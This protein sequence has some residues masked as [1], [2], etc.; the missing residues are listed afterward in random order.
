MTQLILAG[1]IAGYLVYLARKTR[2]SKQYALPTL[3][4]AAA[5]TSL[6]YALFLLFLNASLKPDWSFY[7]MPL[8][9][10]VVALF[11]LLLL[12]FAY[13]FPDL[14]SQ[15][16]REARAALGLCAFYMMAEA[17]F[18]ALRYRALAQGAVLYRP[19][20]MDYFML[21]GFGWV[22]VIFLRQSVRLSGGGSETPLQKLW[23]PRNPAA[24]ATRAL[25]LV[26]LLMVALSLIEVLHSLDLLD[27]IVR[28][29][30]LAF[31]ILVT[32]GAFTLIYLNFL[33]ETT[34]FMVK[35]V[36]VSLAVVLGILGAVGW[37]IAPPY[38]AA[39]DDEN[40]IRGRLTLRFTP[41]R[42][43]A[44]DVEAAP[45][46]FDT[47]FGRP[48]KDEEAVQLPFPFPY[49]SQ[50]W[51]TAYVL[52]NGVLSFGQSFSR[53]NARYRYGASPAIAP[54]YMNLS[55]SAE[56]DAAARKGVFVQTS[57]EKMIVTWSQM[58]EANEPSRAYTFQLAL[59]PD[60]SFEINYADFPE[61]QVFRSDDLVDLSRFTALISG[62]T[63]PRIQR[64]HF[65]TDLPFKGHDYDVLV[66]D[67]YLAFREYLHRL[68]LPLAYVVGLSSLF[69]VLFFP[70]FFRFNLLSPL[71][72]LLQGIRE[73]N[74][75]NL[76]VSMP[77]QFHDEIGFLTESF[78]DMASELNKRSV[79]LQKRAEGLES[80]A[81]ISSAIRQATTKAEIITLLTGEIAR[82]EEVSRGAIFLLENGQ[83]V[84]AGHHKTTG[85]VAGHRL[86]LD[87]MSCWRAL[88]RG[89][90]IRSDR[91]DS[92]A[93]ND[94]DL[95]AMHTYP[96]ETQALLPLQDADQTLGL[97]Y[98]SFRCS[99][100]EL[101]ELLPT[102]V[103]MAEMGGNALQRVRTVEM[104]EQ[105]VQART[106]E[107]TTLVEVAAATTRFTALQPM[108]EEML[109]KTL[110]AIKGELA[111]IHLF[112]EPVVIIRQ[113][114]SENKSSLFYDF[115]SDVTKLSDLEQEALTRQAPAIMNEREL[116][117]MWPNAQ[118]LQKRVWI[119]FPI[120]VAGQTCGVFSLFADAKRVFSVED[121]VLLT[122]IVD[123]IGLAVESVGL[124]R[125]VRE[126]AAQE[127]RSRLGRDL[128][129]SV[130]Q[131]LH[132]LVLLA[133][134][135]RYLVQADRTE[136]LSDSLERLSESA[137]QALKEMRLLLFRLRKDNQ[138]EINI[139][140]DLRTRLESVERRAG[141]R[142]R[143]VVEGSIDW[144]AEWQTEL[145]GIAIEALN[146]ALQHAHATQ[147][148][149]LVKG[150]RDWALL[151][152][153]DNGQGFD[154]EKPVAGGMGL[155]IM[156]ERAQRLGAEFLIDAAPGR[157]VCVRVLL[158][159]NAEKG[160]PNA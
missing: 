106:R 93:C 23:R 48:I 83:L 64:I 128:H 73:I 61:K 109:D 84:Q 76:D 112:T 35:L 44:Y 97:L 155:Q 152:I 135:A 86:R 10:V 113:A 80:L 65:K 30:A 119:G 38:I 96:S 46:R 140:E 85:I 50:T 118:I 79:A 131:S 78:N 49:F 141:I 45:F 43:G 7:V 52:K 149:I 15:W 72:R 25:A 123:H 147:V 17:A 47:D 57:P 88:R 114:Q 126:A 2:L 67:Y 160:A 120:Q 70:V 122:S 31:G 9:S 74:S 77:V 68:F 22:G 4:I 157:G 18:A 159:R 39:Y 55:A 104:L 146:N 75:G 62:T 40:M 130:T 21:A 107:L 142:V 145:R 111:I 66:E 37:I 1:A 26:G 69:I 24:R 27:S 34:S 28:D 150:E 36:G 29:L 154:P 91:I 13:R 101:D 5:L 105:L 8:E 153:T 32:L 81:H 51:Q 121:I 158:N 6:T 82:A 129:D 16:R 94:C 133:D 124:R 20:S 33:P 58:T 100:A 148:S 117:A 144:P 56:A 90:I 60:G 89:M 132:S 151:E 116:M 54:F 59:F 137:R 42:L 19:A 98:L 115:V 92:L 156:A 41:N 71:E 12:Q 103:A 53:H 102:W 138:S 63:R 127:E 139:V 134:T 87:S 11:T 108:L 143:L 95:C 136:Y 125:Q 99:G 14:P 3:L 110:D